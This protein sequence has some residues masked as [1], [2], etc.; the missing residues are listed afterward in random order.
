MAKGR[1]RTVLVVDDEKNIRLTLRTALES[2]QV[3]TDEAVNGEE[4]LSK[5]AER[6]YEIVLLD[7][8]MPGMKRWRGSDATTP[9]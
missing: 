5:L 8:K 4:A 2:I 9:E 3:E 1:R 6:A 7:L